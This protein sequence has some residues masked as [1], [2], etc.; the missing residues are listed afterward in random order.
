MHNNATLHTLSNGLTVLL[1]EEHSAPVIA[2]NALV[3]V[4]SAMESKAEA[5]IAHFIEHML[6]KGTPNRPVG[7]IAYEVEAAGGDINAYT[8]F[9]QTVYYINMASRF[10]DEGIDILGDAI[11]NPLFEEEEIAREAEVICEEIR[12]SDDSASHRLSDLA[13]ANTFG[14]HPYGSPII[15]SY[16]TV[17]SFRQKHLRDFWKRWYTA[18]N[19]VFIV[20]GDFDTKTILPKLERAF[21]GIAKKR[22]AAPKDI[23]KMAK[24]RGCQA[25]FDR[26]PL[27]SSH[28][29]LS[30]P[31][32]DINHDDI[33]LL[34]L[35]AHVLSGGESARLDQA[36]K[37]EQQLVQ[38]IF[39]YAYSA[40]GS[41]IFMLG[42]MTNTPK[43]SK[44]IRAIWNEV[45]QAQQSGIT[46]EEL[47]RAKLS[48][49]SSQ[50]YDKET[51]GG[52]ASKYA[53]YLATAGS[54]DYDEWYFAKISQATSQEVQDI[55]I[56]Y[57]QPERCT[58]SW[59]APEKAKLP[60]APQVTALCAPKGKAPAVHTKHDAAQAPVLKTLSNGTKL[61][62]RS[63]HRLP[64]VSC[65]LTT[66]GG[67]RFETA[68]NNGINTLLA[69]TITKGTSRRSAANIATSIDNMAGSISAASGRNTFGMRADFLSAKM[70]EGFALLGEILQDPLFDADEVRKEQQF[71]LEAIR[72]QQDNYASVAAQH[73]AKALF[74]K[75]P[76]SRPAIG[77]DA[78]VKSISGAALRKYYHSIMRPENMVISIAGDIDQ[79][80][81]E[82][83]VETQ[84]SWKPSGRAFTGNIA[85]QAA[86]KAQTIR[87]QR[88]GKQQAH[89]FHGVRGA[90]ATGKDR[91]AI[92]V[93]N[94]ILSGQG[95]RLF[96]SLRDQL[97][98]AYSVTSMFQLGIEPGYFAV[99]IGTDPSKVDTAIEGFQMHLR[100]LCENDVPAEELGRATQHIVG[101]YDLDLQRNSSV[102]SAY[103]LNVLYGLGLKETQ[104]YPEQILKIT[105]K[106]IKRV[107]RKYLSQ[108]AVCAIVTP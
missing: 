44:A 10:A 67:V 99:Y 28:F 51:V 58:V 8:S 81:A 54:H 92:A 57:V 66:L 40:R 33:P 87:L 14:K 94:Q 6:F 93:L 25:V 106:D 3:K 1:E 76:Y 38:S 27:Q 24:T 84:L 11:S 83:M 20:V 98:L 50:V 55:I 73:F 85:Q 77:S 2:L 68:R 4:G 46:T 69:S 15:G 19:M 16:K 21:G 88:P 45:R 37:E 95:G 75:H 86:S 104:R 101:T 80:S 7:R 9:D 74:G 12:R 63:N 22:A 107:A 91:Y 97:S 29:G 62:V 47:E 48:L 56:Q 60:S 23:T 31:I 64:L 32:P 43:V 96:L 82:R 13:F 17:K 105:A 89:I 70:S 100:D 49:Q 30:F 5:G 59:V 53:Y 34:D 71:Q 39:S 65:Y 41:G 102:A 72:N 90:T 35:A 78:S 79:E 108:E 52:L 36:V 26:M 103:A 18:D 42:G 61:I